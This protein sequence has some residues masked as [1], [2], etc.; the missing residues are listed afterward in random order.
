MTARIES[1]V[2]IVGAGLSGLLAARRLAEAGISAQVVDKGRSPGGRL[3]TRRIGPGRA[4]HGAQ[5]FTARSPEFLAHVNSWLTAG[6]VFVWSHG[7]SAGSLHAAPPD[8]HPRYAARDGMNQI[9]RHLAQGLDLRL[10]TRLTALES[11]SD[12]WLGRGEGGERFHALA[13][14][15]TPPVPQSIDLL[16]NG[17]VRLSAGDMAALQ[18]VT[19]APCLCGLFWIDGLLDLPV[20][21]VLQRP[22][23][24]FTWIADNQQKGISPQARLI[25]AHASPA[26]SRS[27]WGES[28]SAI[29]AD[30]QAEIQS[31]LR[32]GGQVLESQ[33][34]RW[35][36][37]LAETTHPDRILTAQG[38]PPLIFAGDGFGAPRVEGAA[39]SGL[40]AA[41]QVARFFTKG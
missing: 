26:F 36:Y 5:F 35:K 31:H 6:L 23:H 39:L 10:N 2:L 1:Q 29:L 9:A 22:G 21:G 27:R 30:I 15:L 11:A 28:D 19:Y 37:A 33:L 40:A 16:H 32:P 7:W 24:D 8:G 14:I 12:G 25:T 20:P 34:K 18:Q 41:E 17:G 38:M 13:V 4:D 3:A